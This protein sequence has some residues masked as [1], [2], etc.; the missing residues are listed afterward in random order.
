MDS[1]EEHLSEVKRKSFKGFGKYG[2]H[3]KFK[4]KSYD[5]DLESEQLSHRFCTPSH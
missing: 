5:L 2:A 4:G 3:T 1:E